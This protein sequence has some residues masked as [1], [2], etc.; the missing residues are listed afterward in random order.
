M[1]SS[2]RE[3]VLEFVGGAL[4]DIENFYGGG[5]ESDINDARSALRE[6]VEI[7]QPQPAEDT[8]EVRGAV[9]IGQCEDGS[10]AAYSTAYSTMMSDDGLKDEVCDHFEEVWGRVSACHLMRVRVP[11]PRST[12]IEGEVQRDE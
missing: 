1:T 9:A 8:V 7:L 10:W 11:K 6:V 12:T 3:K 2:E 4:I 5:D